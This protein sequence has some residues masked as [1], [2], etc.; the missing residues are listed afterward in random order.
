MEV[1]KYSLGVSYSD[2]ILQVIFTGLAVILGKNV[3]MFLIVL[4]FL[5]Y[6]AYACQE[7]KDFPVNWIKNKI[8]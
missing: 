4:S 5:C 1:K 2:F 3:N 8:I 6:R 7:V